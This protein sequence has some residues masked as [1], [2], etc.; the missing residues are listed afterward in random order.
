MVSEPNRSRGLP[1]WITALIL[2]LA[3]VGG[4]WGLWHYFEGSGGDLP[5][6]AAA[7]LTDANIDGPPLP[8]PNRQR[9]PNFGQFAA[10]FAANMPDGI[11]PAGN[12]FRVRSGTA[13]LDID[14]GNG[15]NNRDGWRYRFSYASPNVESPE[16]L[17]IFQAARRAINDPAAA[18][19]LGVTAGQIQQLRGVQNG[20]IQNAVMV[21]DAADR[22]KIITLFRAWLT[23]TGRSLSPTTRPISLPAPGPAA[24]AAEQQ[25]LTAL[26]DIG[27]RQL[28]STRQSYAERAQRI[29]A[30]LGDGIL[31]KLKPTG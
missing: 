13:R 20:G 4:G 7:M 23:A 19:K 16:Q 24:S 10:R 8:R 14:P 27:N 15:N 17:A 26:A 2:L 12:A 3:L 6:S 29:Q 18:G 1:S 31:Q 11:M 28:A 21:V 9:P 25:L 30:I 5:P 22:A